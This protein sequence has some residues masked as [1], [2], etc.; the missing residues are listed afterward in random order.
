MASNESVFRRWTGAGAAAIIIV[1]LI[2]LE[3]WNTS[4]SPHAS[5]LRLSAGVSAPSDSRALAAAN[6]QRKA[7]ERRGWLSVEHNEYKFFENM[8]FPAAYVMFS[9]VLSCP[10]TFEKVPGSAVQRDGGKWLCGLQELNT[11]RPCIIY[12]A[13]S[14]NDFTFEE[15]INYLAPHCEVHTFDPTSGPPDLTKIKT[16]S[17]FHNEGRSLKSRQR[18]TRVRIENAS[19]MRSA[20]PSRLVGVR[21]TLRKPARE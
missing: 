9:P 11:A 21:P 2:L 13:G 3:Q 5:S 19:P 4:A 15:R 18:D 6:A 14:N 10:G 16:N 1:F 7:A 17:V 12:S 20:S 8:E